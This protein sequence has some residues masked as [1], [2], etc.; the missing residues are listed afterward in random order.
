MVHCLLV[1]VHA[2][3]CLRAWTYKRERSFVSVCF[4]YVCVRVCEEFTH[5]GTQRF[6]KPICAC[7]CMCMRL[8]FTLSVRPQTTDKTFRHPYRHKTIHL[9]VLTCLQTMRT[10]NAVVKIRLFP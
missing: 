6:V 9:N 7:V 8:V 5:A 1:C 10:S 4:L 3:L 2:C